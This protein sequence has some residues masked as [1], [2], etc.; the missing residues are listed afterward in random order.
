MDDE[1]FVERD[2]QV[3]GP[4]T[5]AQLTDGAKRGE[6][7]REHRLALRGNDSWVAA[8]EHPELSKAF[9]N[10]APVQPTVAVAQAPSTV[11]CPHCGGAIKAAAKICK[12][13][14]RPAVQM[15]APPQA[16]AIAVPQASQTP[17]PP[18][19][20]WKRRVVVGVFLAIALV[21]LGFATFR[22][23]WFQLLN[24]TPETFG[25][26]GMQSSSYCNALGCG[27]GDL[28]VARLQRS[29]EQ[30]RPCS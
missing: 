9:P 15:E 20:T 30:V 13:C 6:L 10:A 24:E 19:L 4:F 18:L 14:Q 27:T 7:R 26:I 12:H 21:M 8:G 2:G 5:I 29:P 3:H 17:A 28:S 16:R 22:D 23:V 25:H 1:W 11:P